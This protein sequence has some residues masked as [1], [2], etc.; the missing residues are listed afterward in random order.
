MPALVLLVLL[1]AISGLVSPYSRTVLHIL[2]PVSNAKSAGWTSVDAFTF[3]TPLT[4]ITRHLATQDGDAAHA[5]AGAKASDWEGRP[6]IVISLQSRLV[7]SGARNR[8]GGAFD[9]RRVDRDEMD[10]LSREIERLRLFADPPIW[11]IPPRC[12][13][14]LLPRY[15]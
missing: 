13:D 2:H 6:R 10:I 14:G 12:R 9:H 15:T 4:N 5:A 1:C 11:M 7:A 3:G 8:R